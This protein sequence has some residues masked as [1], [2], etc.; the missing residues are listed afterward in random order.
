MTDRPATLAR[1]AWRRW[2]LVVLLLLARGAS[3]NEP[4]KQVLDRMMPEGW[5]APV[6]RN[7]RPTATLVPRSNPFEE[8]MIAGR[9]WAEVH[10][11]AMDLLT[12]SRDYL[13]ATLTGEAFEKRRGGNKVSTKETVTLWSGHD[14]RVDEVYSRNSQASK[15]ATAYSDLPDEKAFTL[16]GVRIRVKHD[17][18][19]L[20]HIVD[21]PSLAGIS[22]TSGPRSLAG[23]AIRSSR[24]RVLTVFRPQGKFRRV[25][26]R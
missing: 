22:E 2:P 25:R 7:V 15:A 17:L 1:L 16:A 26:A 6:W 19:E 5:S 4:A 14:A 8:K 3:A 21:S 9:S 24:H 10:Q 20:K 13:S 11:M 12:S 23:G 18:G